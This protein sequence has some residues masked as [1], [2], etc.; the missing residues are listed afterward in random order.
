MQE[1]MTSPAP[2]TRKQ[3]AALAKTHGLSRMGMR[4]SI[5]EYIQQTWKQRDFMSSMAMYRLRAQVEENRLGWAWFVIRPILDASIYGAIFGVLQGTSRPPG[6]AAYVVT[7]VFLFNFFTS[8]FSDGSQSVIGSRILVQTLAFPR[9]TLP[10]S[11]VLQD[12]YATLPPLA[13]LPFILML[14]HYGPRLQW[15]LLI[16]L[17]ALLAL[18]NAGMAFFAARITVHLRD[19]AQLIPVISRLLFYTSGVLF[20]VDAIFA[21]HQRIITLYNFHPL[22]QVI[23]IARGIMLGLDYP[24]HYWIDFAISSVVVCILGLLFFWSAE[25]RYGTE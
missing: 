21:G 9:V 25:E 2:M 5:V 4:P 16:P 13:V 20:N 12:F 19:L 1:D 7:G 10:L 22:Y 23:K 6:Y 18:F 24:M 17:L 8:S 11:R 3:L 15:L 14:F